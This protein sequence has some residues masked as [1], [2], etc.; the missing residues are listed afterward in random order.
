M[1]STEATPHDLTQ[2]QERL[3]HLRAL[4][5]SEGWKLARAINQDIMDVRASQIIRTRCRTQEE[6]I[7]QEFDKGN[8]EGREQ[9]FLDID[10][11]IEVLSEYISNLMEQLNES[12]DPQV[13]TSGSLF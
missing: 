3:R 9:A 6:L 5:E 8:I 4:Q 13:P 2:A 7:A 10:T 12:E 1:S 11:E